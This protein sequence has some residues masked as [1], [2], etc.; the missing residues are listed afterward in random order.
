MNWVTFTLAAWLVVGLQMGLAGTLNIGDSGIAPNLVFVLA[1]YIA[2][3]APQSVSLWSALM[4]GLIVDL[5]MGP[6]LKQGGTTTILGPNALGFALGCQLALTMRGLLNRRN[7]LTIGFLSLT[8]HAVAQSVVMGFYALHRFYGDPLA[9][10]GSGELLQRL[11][12]AAYTGVAGIIIG[13][14]LIPA[15]PLFNFTGHQQRRFQR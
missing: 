4:L 7:P 14:A 11:G 13:L 5:I 3:H 12:S 8:G 1:A 15:T 2:T 10:G 6:A 9:P